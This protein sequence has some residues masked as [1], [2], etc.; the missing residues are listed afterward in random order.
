MDT[1][2][3]H[4]LNELESRLVELRRILENDKLEDITRAEVSKEYR[5]TERQLHEEFPHV[6]ILWMQ[7]DKLL[8][9]LENGK[10]IK[11]MSGNVA[12]RK[13]N[14]IREIIKQSEYE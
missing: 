3:I 6:R 14:R 1:K 13:W 10:P 7:A 11:A 12:V 4:R 8:I 2:K 9:Y 5:E